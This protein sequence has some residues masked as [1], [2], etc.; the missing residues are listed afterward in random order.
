LS[1]HNIIH[2]SNEI[3]AKMQRAFVGVMPQLWF[4]N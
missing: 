2:K 1:R 4:I 3:F